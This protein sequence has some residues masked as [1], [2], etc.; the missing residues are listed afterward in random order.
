MTNNKYNNWLTDI[1]A[2]KAEAEKAYNKMAEYVRICCRIYVPE[3]HDTYE[4]NNFYSEMETMIEDIKRM[5]E[6]TAVLSDIH[7]ELATT[8]PEDFED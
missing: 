1:M 6:I 7:Q 2:E 8:T 3:V 4:L 5:M